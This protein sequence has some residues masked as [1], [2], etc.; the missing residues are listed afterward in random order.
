[1]A[2]TRVHL[3]ACNLCEA[4]CGLRI[5]VEGERILSIRGDP[6]DPFSR[7]FLCPKAA[8]LEDVHVDPDR[9]KHPLRRAG[10]RWTR[11]GWE[12]AFDE[13]ADRLRAVQTRHGPD[14]VAVYLGNPNVHSLGALTHAVPFIRTLRTRNRYSATS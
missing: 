6:D 1:M 7:G 3:R 10:D 4:M 14:A 13:V 8:A 5:E 9:H 12:E 11:I 2:E